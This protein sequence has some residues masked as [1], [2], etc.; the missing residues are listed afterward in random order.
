MG[1][2]SATSMKQTSGIGQQST[3]G[4][5]LSWADEEERETEIRGSIWDNF[6]IGKIANA[7]FNWIMLLL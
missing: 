5:K 1:E 6:D 3:D 2:S 7:G 4:S